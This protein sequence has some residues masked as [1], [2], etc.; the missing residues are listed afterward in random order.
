MKLSSLGFLLFIWVSPVLGTCLNDDFDDDPL[1][2]RWT[3]ITG[4]AEFWDSAQGVWYVKEDNVSFN[5]YNT[6]VD[7]FDME[8]QVTSTFTATRGH[9]AAV[10]YNN[11]GALTTYTNYHGG[12]GLIILARWDAG[13]RIAKGTSSD[14]GTEDAGDWMTTRLRAQGADGANVLLDMW[15]TLHD[16]TKPSSRPA[17][18]STSIISQVTDSDANRLDDITLHTEIGLGGRA[19]AN[20]LYNAMDYWM[21]RAVSDEA[22]CGGA[23]AS[24]PE[25]RSPSRVIIFQ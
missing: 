7:S 21:A 18:N 22:G 3:S 12:G 5:S 19:G 8:A 1:G 20:N 24:D 10:R 9:S 2:T 6:T 15:G 17:W 13:T 4:G 25:I 16:T 23:P 14:I 11:A